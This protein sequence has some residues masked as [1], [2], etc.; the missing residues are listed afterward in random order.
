MTLTIPNRDMMSQDMIIDYIILTAIA[1]TAEVIL[2]ILDSESF[3]VEEKESKSKDYDEVTS[4]DYAAQETLISIIGNL[5]PEAGMVG[6][7]KGYN[8]PSLNG[9]T[10][11]F[12]PIDGTKELVRKGNEV[13][14]MIACMYEGRII[15]AAIHN[16][17]TRERYTLM[18][19]T[20]KVYRHR[21]AGPDFRAYVGEEQIFKRHPRNFPLLSLDDM[22]SEVLGYTGF[23][24]EPKIG[25]FH[26]HLI[27]TGSFGTNMMRLASSQVCAV[28]TKANTIYPWDALPVHG[29]LTAMGFKG[30]LYCPSDEIPWFQHDLRL[31]VEEYKQGILLVTQPDIFDDFYRH[32]YK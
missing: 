23:M 6:E 13:G 14:I 2:Q 12:D 25:F 31:E 1:K 5:M 8:K 16:P 30:Y 28:I 4:A 10:F 20:G 27:S 18:A 9:Y 3:E 26:P 32:T 19:K 17:F 22:R 21:A 15:A 24:S 7:E 11:F 29:I